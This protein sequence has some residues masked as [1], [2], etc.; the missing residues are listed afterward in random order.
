[1]AAK[2]KILSMGKISGA[3]T[4]TETKELAAFNVEADF[5][6]ARPASEDELIGI[7]KDVDVIMG[8]GRLF[9]RRVMESLP[10]LRAIVT[11]SVGYDGVDVQAATDNG[12]ILVNNPA[13]AWCMDEVSNHAIALLL[14][15]AK[16]LTLLNSMIKAGHWRDTRGVMAPMAPVHGQTLGLIGCGD[17]GRATATKAECLGMKL[18]GADPYVSDELTID[19]GIRRTTLEDLLRQSD[20][21]SMHTPLEKDTFHMMGEAQFKMMKPTAYFIN[22]SRGRTVDE[23]AL[24]KALQQKWIAGA[25]LDVFETEPVADDNPMLKMDNVIMLP[26]SGSYSDAALDVQPVNPAQEVGRILSGHWPKNPVNRDVKPRVALE[27]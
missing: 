12:I 14:A 3:S 26:H 1:M 7:A 10:K 9:T 27:K 13:R 18:I 21:V 15:C 8:A 16:K 4:G 5:I 22:T 24:I 19:C 11:Y 2:F 6:E 20:F 17:I 23:A 25:G